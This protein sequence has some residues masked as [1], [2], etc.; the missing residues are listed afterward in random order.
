LKK[1]LICNRFG[2]KKQAKKLIFC[3]SAQNLHRCIKMKTKKVKTER[4]QLGLKLALKLG[5]PTVCP[6]L[7]VDENG[8]EVCVQTQEKLDNSA[9]CQ[10]D[11]ETGCDYRLC[12]TFAGWF[13]AE[14]A[15]QEA[16]QAKKE[17]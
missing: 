16:A 9:L 7:K 4:Q 17:E 12:P 6:L 3:Q 5:L 10:L 14:A 1:R 15:K 13:W 11:A 2:E 8:D